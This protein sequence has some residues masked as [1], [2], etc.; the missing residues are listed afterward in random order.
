MT[1]SPD[2]L[3]YGATGY[4]GR[5]IVQHALAGGLR[6]I[7]AGRDEHAVSSMAAEYGL[8]W[9]AA[10]VDE[11]EPVRSMAASANVLL[12]AAAPFATTSGP[13]ID[14]CLATGTHYLD[15][16]GE[17][18]AIEA[19]ARLDDAAVRRGVM[20]MPGVGF[21]VVASD[22]LAVHV[23]RRLPGV[24]ALKLGFDKSQPASRG[25]LKTTVE[26]SGQGVLVRREG[27]LV[28]VPPG[29]LARSFDY[30][31]GP[32]VSLAV[33]LGDL[34]SAFFST[35]VPNIETYLRATLP[36]W[37]AIAIDQYWGWL[38]SSPPWQALLT[39]QIDYLIP[40]PPPHTRSVGWAT[41]VAEAE[42]SCGRCARSRMHT[43]DAY[44]FSALSAV[45]IAERTLA[46]E[47]KS[48]FQTPSRVFG[49][50][51]ALSFEGVRREDL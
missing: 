39:A 37:T 50:D 26:M 4:T 19:T 24:T 8:D 34:S 16:T 11:P 51:F 43:G 40:D 31:H 38:L 13:L 3:I 22:C 14:A 44:W 42:D 32:Q 18:D 12:N 46:G 30:G 1:T 27:Q 47:L 5:L 33:S 23:A 15:I 6:P 49:P 7:I 28:R 25:S 45:A 35:G 48:G 9:R 29:S 2:L 10:R 21:D 36:V 17:A 41:I 20:L